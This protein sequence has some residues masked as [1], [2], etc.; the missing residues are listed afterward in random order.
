MATL[1]VRNFPDDLYETVQAF[2]GE[3]RRSIGAEVIDLMTDAVARTQRKRRRLAALERIKQRRI[4]FRPSID[5]KDSLAL[6]R[7]DRE[8]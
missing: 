4:L 2:A 3:D 8:R 5:G 6:L 7:E 1:Y